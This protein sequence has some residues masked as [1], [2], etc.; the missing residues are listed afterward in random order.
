M[1]MYSP[2]INS[3]H[4]PQKTRPWPLEAKAG[5]LERPLQAHEGMGRVARTCEQS[6]VQVEG[7]SAPLE[8]LRETLG[9]I[10]HICI[11]L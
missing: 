8:D 3:Q 10:K 11:F 4:G 9:P 7:P 2:K 1:S 5:A 6:D